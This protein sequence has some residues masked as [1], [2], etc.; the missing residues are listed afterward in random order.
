MNQESKYKCTNMPEKAQ[1]PGKILQNEC[2]TEGPKQHP[3]SQE[4][5]LWRECRAQG[6]V[7]AGV[8]KANW[9]LLQQALGH[10]RGS[11]DTSAPN[12]GERHCF[13]MCDVC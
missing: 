5:A 12:W 9:E 10:P 6:A 13:Q 8:P 4:G 3:I 1:L 7:C 2:T 11:L